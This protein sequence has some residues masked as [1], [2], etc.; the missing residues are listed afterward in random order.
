MTPGERTAPPDLDQRGQVLAS[1]EEAEAEAAAAEARAVAASA[2]A[3][4]IRRRR[5]AESLPDG[6]EHAEIAAARGGEADAAGGATTRPGPLWRRL[7]W[8]AIL[9]NCV[10]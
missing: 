9:V 10:A 7:S 4:A 8:R 6:H 3:L 2:R 5:E 1:A